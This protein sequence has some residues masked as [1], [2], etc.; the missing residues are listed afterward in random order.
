[1]SNTRAWLAAITSL[2]CLI[3]GCR[4]DPALNGLEK[5]NFYR[6][7][8][9]DE[10][11]AARDKAQAA[12]DKA[13]AAL[14]ACRRENALL[15]KQLEEMG[16]SDRPR[17]PASR[18]S[19]TTPS[20]TPQSLD[21]DDARPPTIEVPLLPLPSGPSSQR[22]K[23]TP[24]S[25]IAPK[26]GSASGNGPTIRGAA[27]VKADNREVHRVT[28]NPSLT[29]GYNKNRL[30]GD[31]GLIVV[32]EPRDAA[33][34]FVAAAAPVSIVLL[35]G[36]L[37][38]EAS[39]VARWDWTA[40]EFAARYRK[41]PL[42]EGFYL[43]MPWPAASPAHGDLHLFVRYNTDDARKL[44]TDRPVHIALAGRPA[45]RWSAVTPPLV[46]PGVPGAAGVSSGQ[47]LDPAA[48]EPSDLQTAARR[49]PWSPERR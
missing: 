10:A 9:K 20:G 30:A 19:D 17:S 16:A 48:Q 4:T 41:T 34:N 12:R 22:P 35:D 43:E 46:A 25:P 33:G 3:A 32:I 11:E 28:L 37:T 24:P 15:K 39:R 45:E 8:Q 14:D 21:P 42:M 27:L 29:G 2:A 31:D 40:A 5:E 26:N 6:E 23:E 18:G 38:G 36:A 7:V 47:E 1:M 44:E 49:L 13:Q